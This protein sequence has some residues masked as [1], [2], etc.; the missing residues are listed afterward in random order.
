MDSSIIHVYGENW[1]GDCRR[2]KALLEAHDVP[3]RWH[4]TSKDREARAFVS[5]TL[6]GNER[7]PLILFPDGSILVEPTNAELLT[8]LGLST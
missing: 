6:P 3:F 1:C 8:E 7:I 2:A 4:D 5:R